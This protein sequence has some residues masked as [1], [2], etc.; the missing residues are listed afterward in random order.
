[1]KVK[2][3]KNFDGLALIDAEPFVDSRGA[4]TRFFCAE[5]LSN[6][7]GSKSI[8][9]VNFSKTVNKG[10][11]R[12]LHFQYPPKAEAKFVRCIRGR[13]FDVIV[14]VRKGSTSYLKWYGFELDSSRQNMVYVPEG[15][16]HGFQTLESNAE[17]LYLHTEYHSRINEDGLRYDDPLLGI[18][19]P[20]KIS[21]VSEK[22]NN[23]QYLS[24]KFKAVNL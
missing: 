21:D 23:H 3:V 2:M 10:S 13:V 7:L 11:V 5:E 8:V 1:M 18:R 16:A 4:F 14:D 22:D 12:G 6:Q 20:L 15:F 19:W 9:N 24:T 17:L